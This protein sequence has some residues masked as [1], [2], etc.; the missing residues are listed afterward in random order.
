VLFGIAGSVVGWMAI[1]FM[2]LGARMSK[3]AIASY[4]EQTGLV[5]PFLFDY[6]VLDRKF[7]VTDGIGITLLVSLQSV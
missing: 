1:E 2:I 7:L 4:A 6:L 3:S 5:P